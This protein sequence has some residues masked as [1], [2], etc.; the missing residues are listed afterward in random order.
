MK[1]LN[2]KPNFIKN[3]ICSKAALALQNLYLLQKFDKS[4]VPTYLFLIDVWHILLTNKNTILK[5][6]FF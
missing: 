4:P 6:Y 2:L 3:T 1:K 5:K